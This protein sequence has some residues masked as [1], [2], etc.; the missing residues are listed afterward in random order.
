MWTVAVVLPESVLSGGPPGHHG[1]CYQISQ[2]TESW[3]ADIQ[4]SISRQDMGHLHCLRQ[5]GTTETLSGRF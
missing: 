4:Q 1:G 3:S 5:L 2:A